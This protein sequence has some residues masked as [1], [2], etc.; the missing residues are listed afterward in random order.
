MTTTAAATPTITEK[1]GRRLYITLPYG[2]R[3]KDPIKALGAHWD[4]TTKRWWITTAKTAQIE[5]VLAAHDVAGDI[6]DRASRRDRADEIRATGVE[7][8]IPYAETAIR[9]AAKARGAVWNR[10][11]K[12]WSVPAEAADEIRGMIAAAREQLRPTTPRRALAHGDAVGHGGVCD[13]CGRPRRTLVAAV[14]RSGI[15]GQVCRACFG[16]GGAGALSFG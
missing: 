16:R 2:S 11:V 14:D 4:A 9:E 5:A 8:A 13:E 7:L 1:I 15:A 3:A 12:T 6:T 10:E